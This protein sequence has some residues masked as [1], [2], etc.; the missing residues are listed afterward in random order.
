MKIAHVSTYA[1]TQ[2]GI[3][4]FCENMVSTDASLASTVFPIVYKDH[5][6]E[7]EIQIG[8]F[9]DYQ[10]I[11]KKI[12]SEQF[13]RLIIQHE[14]GIFGGKHGVF[15]LYFLREI[16]IPVVVVYHTIEE[17]LDEER[18]QI[19]KSAFD[20]PHRKIFLSEYSFRCAEKFGFCMNDALFLRHGAVVDSHT[21]ARQITKATPTK[22][23]TGGHWRQAKGL[24]TTLD[25]LMGLAHIGH[26]FSLTII[27]SVQKQFPDHYYESEIISRLEYYKSEYDILHIK[28]FLNLS[29]FREVLVSCNVGLALYQHEQQS[30]SGFIPDML[31]CGL[32]VLSTPFRYAKDT[33]KDCPAILCTDNFEAS[34]FV[35][36]MS[37][38]LR[39]PNYERMSVEA[40]KFAGASSWH[41]F[42]REVLDQK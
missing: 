13:E 25:A 19:L 4:T 41:K 17:G 30:S 6:Y 24:E 15:F 3:A 23:I 7:D 20:I 11:A 31:S 10:R 21:N 9:D 5:A 26:E 32:P 35:D 34:D 14:F 8:V 29:K 18:I 40:V 22:F 36:K 2:C 16:S 33:M 27:G 38:V 1:P 42:L 12:G 39:P 37:V 28:D